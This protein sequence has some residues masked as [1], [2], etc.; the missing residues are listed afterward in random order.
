MVLEIIKH[1]TKDKYTG[2]VL[3]SA[4]KFDLKKDNWKEMNRYLY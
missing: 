2:M 1:F 4:N 3:P